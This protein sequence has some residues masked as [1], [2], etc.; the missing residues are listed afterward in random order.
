MALRYSPLEA[1]SNF[2]MWPVAKRLFGDY[3]EVVSVGGGIHMRVHGDM[4]DMVNKSLLFCSAYIPFAWE[5]GTARFVRLISPKVKCVVVAG[6]HIG[7]Y[8]LLIGTANSEAVV[9]AFEPNPFIF[10]K[11]LDNLSLNRVQNVRPSKVALG[12]VTEQRRMYFDF[13]QS[14]LVETGRPHAGAGEVEVITLDE[15]FAS[16]T[17]LPD[18]MILDAEGYEPSILAG[19]ASI[20]D[21]S[22]PNVIFELNPKTL[23]AAGSSPEQLCALFERRGYSLFIIDD[24]HGYPTDTAVDDEPRLFAYSESLLDGVSFANVFATKTPEKVFA[25]VR[26]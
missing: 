3:D 14:S 15:V 12:D 6:A 26:L 2:L 16:E 18:L 22:M 13:G 21:R 5:P 24:R 17:I 23:R 9:Y 7:Y 4:E 25:Y 20:L 19:A 11:L 8:P 1:F 10:E